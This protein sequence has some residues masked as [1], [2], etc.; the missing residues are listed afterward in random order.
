MQQNKGMIFSL[1]ELSSE[2][3]MWVK[4]CTQNGIPVNF[5]ESHKE[6]FGKKGDEPSCRWT[7]F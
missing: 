6:Y 4:S 1:S 2:T 7:S 3:T 5:R